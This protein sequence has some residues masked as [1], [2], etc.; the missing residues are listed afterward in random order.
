MARAKI[1]QGIPSVLEYFCEK[2]TRDLLAG[3][4]RNREGLTIRPKVATM[5]TF[6]TGQ[7][8]INPTK[9]PLEVTQTSHR[10]QSNLHV[11]CSLLRPRRIGKRPALFKTASQMETNGVGNAARDPGLCF[12]NGRHRNA[13]GASPPGIVF[14]DNPDWKPNDGGFGGHCHSRLIIPCEVYV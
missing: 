10:L 11:V 13:Y 5:R 12:V 6:L 2:R 7:R 1:I 4:R 3:M 9:K 8:N 14:F